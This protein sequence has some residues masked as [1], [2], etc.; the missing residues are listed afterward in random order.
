MKVFLY[1]V[2]LFILM[3]CN[4]AL[5]V[6]RDN[7]I[8]KQKGYLIVVANNEILF[9]FAKIDTNLSIEQNLLANKFLQGIR[10]DDLPRSNLQALLKY[11]TTYLPPFNSKIIPVVYEYRHIKERNPQLKKEFKQW[12]KLWFEIGGERIDYKIKKGDNNR[13]VSI[14][15]YISVEQQI[16]LFDT[17]R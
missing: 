11:S 3:G 10:A 12:E 2:S 8:V 7:V 16:A 14:R 1:V 17:T 4:R 9:L 15:P 6:N 13:F 5:L